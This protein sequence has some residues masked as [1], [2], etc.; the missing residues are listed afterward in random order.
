[1]GFIGGM[2]RVPKHRKFDYIPQHYDPA[3]EEL[4]ERLAPYREGAKDAEKVKAG[5]RTGFKR[6]VATNPSYSTSKKA[7]TIR[8]VAIICI[9]IVLTLLFLRSSIIADFITAIES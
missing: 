3:K 6:R 5:I 2:F 7:S 9:L 8:L 4:E 1:M